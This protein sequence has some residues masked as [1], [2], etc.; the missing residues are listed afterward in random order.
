MGSNS[1]ITNMRTAAREFVT[2]V[3]QANESDSGNL[4][5]ISIIPYNGMVN[6]GEPLESVFTLSGE[7]SQSSCVRFTEEQFTRTNID[8]AEE[9]ERIA[10]WDYDHYFWYSDFRRPYCP[11]DNYGAILPWE[12]DE[13]VLHAFIDN[14]QANGW[15][16]I[17]LG[18]KMGAAMLDPAART[19]VNTLVGSN[20]VHADFTD[21]P[22]DFG[23]PETIK[24]VVLMTDGENTN[25]YD[26]RQPYKRGFSTI[27]YHVDDDRYSVYVAGRADHEDYWIS[28]GEPDDWSGYWSDEPYLGD[29]SPALSWPY[30]WANYTGRYIAERYLYIPAAQAGNWGLYNAIRNN[31]DELYAGRTQADN[32]LRAICDAAN[33]Q[34]I[35]VFSIGFE[36]PSG[37]RE[38]MQ[39]CASSPA[40]YYDVQGIEISDAFASIAR[41]INQLRL[42][43]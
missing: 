23:N 9:I 31:G 21:R 6:L 15:T 32:N 26:V 24:V 3:L 29:E 41:T 37:G 28:N 27:H 40:H 14:L 13:D 25:Q 1:R 4:V 39:Y 12:H 30:L 17:D 43:Q 10:H 8:P 22:A 16:A 7:H 2:T 36:A 34:N 11:T 18:M 5:S 19:A 33:A 42:I 35:M 38:V 20:E